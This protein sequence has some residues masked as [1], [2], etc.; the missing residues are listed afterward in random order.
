MI[1]SPKDQIHIR[2]LPKM[3]SGMPLLLGDLNQDVASSCSFELRSKLLA[4]TKAI[5]II[6]K[7]FNRVN[8]MIST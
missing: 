3:I 2:I 6:C 7:D 5:W 1:R 4:M 8:N